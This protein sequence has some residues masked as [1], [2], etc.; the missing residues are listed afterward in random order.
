MTQAYWS[1]P[2]PPEIANSKGI[3][4]PKPIPQVKTELLWGSS[5]YQEQKINLLCLWTTVITL[6]DVFRSH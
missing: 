2:P 3:Y 4:W 5:Q 1:L 6:A